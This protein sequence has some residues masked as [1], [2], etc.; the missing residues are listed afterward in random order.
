MSGNWIRLNTVA[1]SSL[2]INPDNIEYVESYSGSEYIR[3]GFPSSAVKD[4]T[5]N[6]WNQRELIQFGSDMMNVRNA[7][8]G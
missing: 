2:L 7:N 3:I 4:V 8:R 1:G 6:A 5:V